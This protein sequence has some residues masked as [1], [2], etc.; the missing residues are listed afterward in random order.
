MTGTIVQSFVFATMIATATGSSATNFYVDSFAKSG[1]SGSSASPLQTIQEGIN[2]L[3]PGDTLHIRGNPL[4][5]GRIYAETPTFRVSGKTNAP[6]TVQGFPGEKVVITTPEMVRFDRDF[7]VIKNLIFDHQGAA[8]DAVR[9]SGDSIDLS[10]CE[11]K[12]GARDAI[13]I[14]GKARRVTYLELCHSR[15]HLGRSRST[16]CPLYCGKPGG[17]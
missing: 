13:D 6:I 16:R 4:G 17:R 14:S 1:G 3:G 5:P 2:K 8:N 11:I 7:L 15:F 12:N 9:W 10:Q